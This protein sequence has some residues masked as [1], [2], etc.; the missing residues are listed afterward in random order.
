[1]FNHRTAVVSQIRG[2]LLD[3]GFSIAKSITRA[4]RAI[5]RAS[6]RRNV[7]RRIGPP[8][9]R[10]DPA[11]LLPPAHPFCE[12]LASWPGNSWN[13]SEARGGPRTPCMVLSPGTI[14]GRVNVTNDHCL[15]I[16]AVHPVSSRRGALSRSRPQSTSDGL[17]WGPAHRPQTVEDGRLD[18]DEARPQRRVLG[19][20]RADKRGLGIT[21]LSH[22]GVV[23]E[24]RCR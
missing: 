18:V 16:P 8:P 22:C 3:R 11:A 19:Q 24:S 14:F 2:F 7:L 5:R 10:A 1:M 23:D 4:R 9:L 17:S 21:L 6:N 12:A 15:R 20:R 13:G